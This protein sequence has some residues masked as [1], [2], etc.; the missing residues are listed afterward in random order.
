MG[1]TIIIGKRGFLGNSL[2]KYLHGRT[3][4]RLISFSDFKNNKLKLKNYSH[5]INC[6]INSNYIK[7]KY[8]ERFDNDLIISNLIKKNKIKLI[9]LSSRKIYKSGLN[10]KENSKLNPKSNYSKNKLITERKLSEILKRKLVILRVS[11]IIGDKSK[12]RNLHNTFVDTFF[13]NAKKGLIF[14]NKAQYK[15]FISIE[16]FNEIMFHIIKKDL[17]GIYNVSIGR[18]ININSLVNWLNHYNK[19]NCRIKNIK[20]NQQSFYLNNNKLMKKIRIK[21]SIDDLKKYCLKLSKKT[22]SN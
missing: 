18:K 9:F 8:N 6:S 10:L 11:N 21:N 1:K 5:I 15:D 3:N 16:K 19:K 12:T 22:F 7:K 13:E 17:N 20:K 4:C 14:N 2:H